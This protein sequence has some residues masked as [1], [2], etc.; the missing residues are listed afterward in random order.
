MIDIFS[1]TSRD[2]GNSRIFMLSGELDASTCRGLLELLQGP[3]ARRSSLICPSSPSWTPRGWV[4][5]TW[6]GATR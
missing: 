5:F 6:H 3:P 2:V 4:P 1:V